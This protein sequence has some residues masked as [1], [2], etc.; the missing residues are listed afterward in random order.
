MKTTC[1]QGPSL[2]GREGHLQLGSI[3]AYTRSM[4]PEQ[5][6]VQPKSTLSCHTERTLEAASLG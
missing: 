6:K 3:E 5:E 1:S 4:L 2:L